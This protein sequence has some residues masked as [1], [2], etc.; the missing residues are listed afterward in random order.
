[1]SLIAFLP[2]PTPLTPHPHPSSTAV[3]QSLRMEKIEIWKSI[4]GHLVSYLS[5]AHNKSNK[6]FHLF[7]ENFPIT[8]YGFGYIQTLDRKNLG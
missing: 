1:M 6:Y 2:S 7:Q 8:L 5:N 3:K 4:I